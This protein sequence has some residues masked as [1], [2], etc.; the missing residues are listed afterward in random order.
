MQRS[1]KF[2]V[3]M[4]KTIGNKVYEILIGDKRTSSGKRVCKSLR[5]EEIINNGL[6]RSLFKGAKL[7]PSRTN[8]SFKNRRENLF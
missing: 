4:A 6:I 3:G 8:M 7:I 2:L 5:I 1:D